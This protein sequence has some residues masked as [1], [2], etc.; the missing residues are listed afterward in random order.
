MAKYLV[1]VESPA[2][3]KTIKKYL[4]QNYKIK[5]S[6]GHIRDLPK[7]RMGV[8]IKNDFEPKYINIRGKGDLISDLK[9]EAKDANK[10]YLATDPDREG[11]AISWHLANI[12]NIDNKEKCR[13]T[14]NEITKNAV[15]NAIKTPRIIDMDLVDAQQARRILDRIVGYEI[16]P[17]LWRNV[18]KGLSAGRVQSVA[19][20]MICD[21]EQEIESFIPEEYWKIEALLKTEDGNSFKSRF[22]GYKNKKLDLPRKEDVDKVLENLKGNSFIVKS[23][24]HG[25]KKRTPAPPFITSTLQ[26]EAARKLGFSTKK[27]MMLAQQLYEGVEVEGEGSIGL[28]T[29][30]RTDST[31]I[32]DEALSK[33]REYVGKNYGEKYLPEKARIYKTKSAAQDAHEAIRPTTPE[34]PP[35]KVKGSL[36]R[37]LYRLYKLIWERFIASQME[38]AVYDTMAIDVEA[39]DYLFKSKGSRIAFKGFLIL[40][41]ESVD[42]EV[43]DENEPM[44]PELKEG[45]RVKPIEIKPSQHFTQPPSRYTEAMLVKALEEKGIGRPSTYAPTISTI[46]SRGYVVKEKKFLIPTELG[47]IVNRLMEEYFKDIVNINFTA[48]MEAQLD[49]VESGKR[50]WKELLYDFYKDFSVSIKDASEKISKVELPVEESD[51]VCEKCGRRMVIKMGRYGKFLACPGF[52]ECRN[53]KPILDDA[54]V[55]CP[56]CGGKIFNKKTRK[57]KHY[58]SCENYPNCDFSSWEIVSDKKCPK[59]GNFMTKKYKGNKIQYTCSLESCANVIEE[60]R[61]KE[62]EEITV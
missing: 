11:E 14:F 32:S 36:Q 40:Y 19:T 13:V 61:K 42:E 24:K 31:R 37:D 59:C 46:I 45:E 23:V 2:K 54:G 7:S 29:Y 9:K 43:E 39:G 17:L 56:K 62:E 35:E 48:D 41:E 21:R 49:S 16:S 5:A 50:N 51:E 28:I 58:L 52:P 22:F 57:G 26:Q 20:K 18:R 3:A 15:T 8:D 6:M 30:M 44:L 10:I 1:I 34:L 12:L 27:T 38:S 55:V 53:A 33:A 60:A 4:G 25:E 47:K